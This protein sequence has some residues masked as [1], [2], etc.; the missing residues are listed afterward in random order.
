MQVHV[1][2]LKSH[3]NMISEKIKNDLRGMLKLSQDSGNITMDYVH[4][5]VISTDK[6]DT[7]LQFEDR[8]SPILPILRFRVS[9]RPLAESSPYFAQMFR[10][11]LPNKTGINVP[12][13]GF[14]EQL[15][16]ELLEPPEKHIDADGKEVFKYRIPQTKLNMGESLSIFFHAA[17][18]HM[19]PR[20]IDLSLLTSI[21]EL[22][23]MYRCTS[24]V[25]YFVERHWVPPLLRSTENETD[26]REALLFVSFVFG[27]QSLFT[28]LSSSIILETTHETEILKVALW[29]QSLRSIIIFAREDLFSQIYTYCTTAMKVFLRIEDGSG[30]SSAESRVFATNLRCTEGSQT[31]DEINLGWMTMVFNVLGL[32]PGL[33]NDIGMRNLSPRSLKTI[34]D[35]LASF[36]SAA[37]LDHELCD[38]AP[39]LRRAVKEIQTDFSG[40]TL[41]K[42]TEKWEDAL[43][44]PPNLEYGLPKL[45]RVQIKGQSLPITAP[46]VIGTPGSTR[47]IVQMG[48]TT[49][50]ADVKTNSSLTVLPLAPMN[51][52]GVN[53]EENQSLDKQTRHTR[54]GKLLEQDITPESLQLALSIGNPKRIQTLLEENF[55]FVAA[56]KF[57]WLK[58]LRELG[59][60][61]MDISQLLLSEQNDSPWIYFEPKGKPLVPIIVNYHQHYCVHTGG[62]DASVNPS[63]TTAAG[64]ASR[65]RKY[66]S[67]STPKDEEIAYLEE[68]CGLAGIIPNTRDLEKWIGSAEFKEVED[69]LTVSVSFSLSS[70]YDF[71]GNLEHYSL[72]TCSRVSK[73]LDNLCTAIG[74]AQ[75]S[76]MCCDS[77]TIL[78]LNDTQPSQ[79]NVE[80][81]R[82]PVISISEFRKRLSSFMIL[83]EFLPR[84]ELE[85]CYN[86]AKELIWQV[87]P[88]RSNRVLQTRSAGDEIDACALATQILCLGFASYIK[89]HIGIFHPFFLDSPVKTVNL[90]GSLRL[91]NTGLPK[92]TVSLLRLTCM[93]DMI[94]SPVMVFYEHKNEKL[95]NT[96]K[97]YDLLASPVDLVDTWGPGKFLTSD[98]EFS[99]EK[100]TC[101]LIG[102][103][104]IHPTAKDTKILHW[105]RG[106]ES[107]FDNSVFFNST[108]KCLIS[109]GVVVNPNC[110]AS[111]GE[112]WSSFLASLKTLGTSPDYWK[113]TETEAG[114]SLLGQQFVGVQ[115]QFNKTWTWHPGNSWKTQYLSLL[116]ELPF[117]ELDRPWGLQVSCCTGVARRVPLRAL[118]ADVMPTFAK[119]LALSPGWPMLQQRGI[120]K[121]LE[122]GGDRFK[123]WYDDLAHLENS[124]ELQTL[125][126]R[127]IR[128]ILLVLRDT[129]IDREHKN[130]LIACPQDHM[131]GKPISMCLPVPC[132]NASLWAKILTDSEQCATFA[133]MTTQCFESQDHK[134]Q[135][136]NPW[137]CPSLD[138]AVQQ[139]RASNEP[140]LISQ[141][142]WNLTHNTKFWIGTPDSGLQAKVVRPAGSP[143][144]R[145]EIS[146][147]TVPKR[148]RARLG[149]MS[150]LLPK[151]EHLRERQID[152]WPAEDVLVVSPPR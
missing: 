146:E 27:L 30:A 97:R 129:G 19:L 86:C 148:T 130:F 51:V 108:D 144:T 33:E 47:K 103:G 106:I 114:F 84:S 9:C 46:T 88:K 17:H 104:V 105:S 35:Q 101:I 14:S 77:F 119:N 31:C 43:P 72:Q 70:V 1:L 150:G 12:E 140:I 29:P 117:S 10:S 5:Y 139:L 7:I 50:P 102:G 54:R 25:E 60:G 131:A 149:V 110:Q 138:T 23:L 53:I 121:A 61:I 124:H 4:E 39:A 115:L 11:R 90:Y 56:G 41:G 107:S 66:W 116:D 59:Y 118:L 37:G 2:C 134:C 147:S 15:A 38:Y 18:S 96:E 87:L 34:I 68:L 126:K 89:A 42:M 132:E 24:V 57:F 80:L 93:E 151:M 45:G 152:T 112:R 82:I 123:Q 48:S 136:T 73:A 22:C 20:R 100:L 69:F 145:L 109:G 44:K 8:V 133:C 142:A 98:S 64:S 71:V 127:V 85:K 75:R 13:S 52:S 49:I 36:P 79:R 137:H 63:T 95:A 58:E 92:V 26:S 143:F 28:G 78:R 122:L 120:T 16:I 6:G 40:L 99:L 94:Q 81:A 65:L 74:C 83:R 91:R 113:G 141:T 62:Q 55:E 128:H 125:A 32:H 67:S 111:R 3:F 135:K 21:A 76:G